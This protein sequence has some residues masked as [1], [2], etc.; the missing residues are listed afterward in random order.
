M[1][2]LRMLDP[3]RLELVHAAIR[4]GIYGQIEWKS[5]AYELVRKDPKMTDF[6][7]ARV[8][9]LLRDFVLQGNRLTERTE[10]R[11]EKLQ[12]D[13]DDP[14][15]YRAIIPVPEFPKGL[16]V[17]VRILDDDPQDPWVQ[18]VSAHEQP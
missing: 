2:S 10:Q 13:P 7:P 5:S 16:F 9:A 8:R 11:A 14:C 17:E 12:D 6:P 3:S 4:A 1:A 15:W 18:I